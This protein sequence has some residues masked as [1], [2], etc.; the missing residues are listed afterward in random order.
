MSHAEMVPWTSSSSSLISN[1]IYRSRIALVSLLQPFLR[2]TTPF[3]ISDLVDFCHTNRKRHN[4]FQ[5]HAKIFSFFSRHST[6]SA[7]R[8]DIEK[9]GVI[10]RFIIW[11]RD[12]EILFSHF[13]FFVTTFADFSLLLERWRNHSWTY[14]TA[15]SC[16]PNCFLLSSFISESDPLPRLKRV[17]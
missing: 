16:T 5:K 3:F 7:R 14:D 15:S 9:C 13:F 6:T 2:Y 10:K 17:F 11:D 4:A 12:S 8:D 1:S